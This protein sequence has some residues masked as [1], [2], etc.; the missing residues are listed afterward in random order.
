MS[1]DRKPPNSPK[2]SRGDSFSLE[3]TLQGVVNDLSKILDALE[4]DPK[5]FCRFEN[6]FEKSVTLEQ[7]V[8]AIG[9]MSELAAKNLEAR[10]LPLPAQLDDSPPKTGT[11]KAKV[12]LKKSH[13][14]KPSLHALEPPAQ[15]IGT[16]NYECLERLLQKYEAEIRDHVRIEQQMK[17]Y[18]DSLEETVAAL[19]ARL[20][21]AEAEAT[22]SQTKFSELQREIRFTRADSKAPKHSLPKKGAVGSDWSLFHPHHFKQVSSDYVSSSD[23]PGASSAVRGAAG[24]LPA[25]AALPPPKRR[26]RG[27]QAVAAGDDAS[28][29]DQRGDLPVQQQGA[30]AEVS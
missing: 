9:Q 13:R 28:E 8:S 2:T 5:I 24:P 21:T 6:L 16:Q 30:A 11:G 25:T 12:S 27:K 18:A 17:I 1:S 4:V 26:P 3:N 22:E 19:Q 14:S 10:G 7:V 23:E 20:K 29:T 15:E